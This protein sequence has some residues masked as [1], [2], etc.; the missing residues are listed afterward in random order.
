M[1]RIPT[2]TSS[3][4]AAVR[5]PADWLLNER[6]GKNSGSSITSCDRYCRIQAAE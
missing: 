6:E 5:R 3:A 1:W 4:L 2:A